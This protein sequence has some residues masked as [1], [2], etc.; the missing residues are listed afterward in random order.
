MSYDVLRVMFFMCKKKEKNE[1]DRLVQSFF[2]CTWSQETKGIKSKTGVRAEFRG[3]IDRVKGRGR[4]DFD[5]FQFRPR[6]FSS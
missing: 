6:S 5:R 1:G 4:I 2:S 3:E